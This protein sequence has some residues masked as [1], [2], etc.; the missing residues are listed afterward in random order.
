ILANRYATGNRILNNNAADNVT[1]NRT[2]S[3]QRVSA[4]DLFDG[5]P[6]CAG[7]LWSGNRWGSGGYNPFCVT[8]GGSGPNPTLPEGSAAAPEPDLTD[9]ARLLPPLE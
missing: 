3:G 8:V 4:F 5:T 1:N 2:K 6:G 7:N 9:F